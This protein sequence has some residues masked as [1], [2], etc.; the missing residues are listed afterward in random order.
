MDSG[1]AAR[2]ERYCCMAGEYGDHTVQKKRA[3]RLAESLS[4]EVKSEGVDVNRMLPSAINTLV[5][6]QSMPGAQCEPCFRPDDLVG[7][8]V[9]PDRKNA[10][11]IYAASIPV[12]ALV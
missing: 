11:A 2:S 9:F 5:N 10:R 8:I 3:K 7:V 1:A 4:A 12:Q 6:R